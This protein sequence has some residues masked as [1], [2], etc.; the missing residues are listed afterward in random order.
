MLC[1]GGGGL[2]RLVDAFHGTPLRTFAG[3]VNTKNLRLEASFSPDS[4]FVFSGSSDSLVHVWNAEHGHKVRRSV[5]YFNLVT[6]MLRL[7]D[8]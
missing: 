8:I 6:A 4:Q 7:Q 3:F 5:F 2:I 1:G